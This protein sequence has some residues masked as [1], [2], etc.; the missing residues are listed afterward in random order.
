MGDHGRVPTDDA[1][2][3]SPHEVRT[4]RLLVTAQFALI[5]LLVVRPGRADSPVPGWLVVLAAVGAV[6]GVVVMLVGGTALGRGPTAVPLPNWHAV[7]RT[8]G[9]YRVVRHP[10]YTGLLLTMG[11]FMVASGSAWRLVVFAALLALVTVKARLKEMVRNSKLR[12]DTAHALV[13]YAVGHP[14]F[15]V[16]AVERDLGV[17]YARANN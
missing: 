8:G 4:A 12:A 5:G 3:V 6:L 1:P 7:L 10:I 11:S 14:S 17:S 9:L 16:R 15:T 13:D 2:E